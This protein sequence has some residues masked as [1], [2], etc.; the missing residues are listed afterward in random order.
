MWSYEKNF[1]DPLYFF[2]SLSQDLHELPGRAQKLRETQA[3]QG[4]SNRNLL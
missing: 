4:S 3:A 2:P 1:S